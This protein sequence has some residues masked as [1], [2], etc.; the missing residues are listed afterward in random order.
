MSDIFVQES[1]S[2]YIFSIPHSGELLISEMKWKLTEEA[3]RTA[4]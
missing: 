3:D 1:D 4:Y 2:P